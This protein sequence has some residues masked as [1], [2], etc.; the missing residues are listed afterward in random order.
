MSNVLIGIIGVILFIGL[1]LAGA[2]FLGDRFSNT[3]TQ[4]EA[5]RYMSEGS[6]IS[7]AYEMFRLN[8]GTYPDGEPSSTDADYTG[9]DADRRKLI[10]LKRGGYLKSIPVGLTTGTGSGNGAWYVDDAKGAAFS[11]IGTD[12]QHQKICTEARKQAGLTD[13]IH[14]CTDTTMANNDPCCT[15]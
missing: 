13:A 14:A 4:S 15:G 6:Q 7:K 2:L 3:K 10:Q 12:A 1:A 11:L 8:E 5:A 9:A